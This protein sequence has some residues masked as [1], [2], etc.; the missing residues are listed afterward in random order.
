[1]DIICLYCKYC[2]FPRTSNDNGGSCKC[3]IMKNKTIDVYVSGG[4]VPL[5]CPRQK[6]EKPLNE[7]S[8]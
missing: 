6:E 4:E 3:K 5:W 7:L 8:K 2:R 1:M